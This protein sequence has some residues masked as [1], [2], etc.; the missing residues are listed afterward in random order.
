M[1][2]KEQRPSTP[3]KDNINIDIKGDSDNGAIKNMNTEDDDSRVGLTK[4]ELMKYADEPFWIRLRNILFAAFWIIWVSTLIAAI[5]YVV[6]S[7]GCKMVSAAALN[8]TATAST[9]PASG[10]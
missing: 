5:G 6:H 10:Q 8:A 7:P 2:S 1:D 3:G 9:T 4:E